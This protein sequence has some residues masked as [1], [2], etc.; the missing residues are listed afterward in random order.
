MSAR[1]GSF[2]F[3]RPPS[4]RAW[5]WTGR[6]VWIRNRFGTQLA[7]GDVNGDGVTDLLA[8]SPD[9]AFA[10]RRQGMANLFFGGLQGLVRTPVWQKVGGN[11]AAVGRKVLLADVN[12]DGHADA[13][14]ATSRLE[15][16]ISTPGRVELFLGSR[17]G[18]TKNAIWSAHG[19]AFGEML[20]GALATADVNGDG[21]PDL[22]L[23]APGDAGG[24]NRTGRVYDFLGSPRGF[25][26]APGQMLS[27]SVNKSAF[28]DSIAA[29]GDLNGDGC[30]EIVV[31]APGLSFE[32]PWPGEASLH[33]GS[34]TGLVS[35]AAWKRRGEH[36]GALFGKCVARAGDINGDGFPDL[37]VGAPGSSRAESTASRV[38]LWLG[39]SMGLSPRPD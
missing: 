25:P 28:G 9:Y 18:L 7:A 19:A 17:N 34:R 36:D 3:R 31:G 8:G 15:P 30:A 20:G 12:R 11:S 22:L 27:G 29:L 24:E 6:G 37:L 39:Q 38:S 2:H 21:W 14:V 13:L 35:T 26:S 5:I 23:G 1:C 32:T 4:C 33:F 10:G 16:G